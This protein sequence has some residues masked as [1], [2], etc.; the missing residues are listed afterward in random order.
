VSGA[1][2]PGGTTLVGG[3]M[4]QNGSNVFVGGEWSNSTMRWWNYRIINNDALA[5]KFTVWSRC[6]D[7][8]IKATP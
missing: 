6:L 8:P 1:A 7:T 4:T 5:R 2:C 3:E